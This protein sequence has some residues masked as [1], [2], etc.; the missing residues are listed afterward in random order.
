[1]TAL[2][3]AFLTAIY[4]ALAWITGAAILATAAGAALARAIHRRISR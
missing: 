3:E 4:G 1:M 2:P